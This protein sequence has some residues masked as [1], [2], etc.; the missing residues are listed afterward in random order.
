MTCYANTMLAILM[1]Y[2]SLHN[3]LVFVLECCD[4]LN[5]KV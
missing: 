4:W 2:L 5:R 1:A 3:V